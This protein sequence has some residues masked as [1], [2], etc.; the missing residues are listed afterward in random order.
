MMKSTATKES[1]GGI[2]HGPHLIPFAD[3]SFAFGPHGDLGKQGEDLAVLVI[4]LVKESH[5]IIVTEFFLLCLERLLEFPCSGRWIED[6]CC[7]M[8]KRKVRNESQK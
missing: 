7:P 2:N 6:T 3:V 1:R 4:W 8:K 5:E